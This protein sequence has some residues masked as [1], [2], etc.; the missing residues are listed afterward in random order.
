[1]PAAL[2][3]VDRVDSVR[4]TLDNGCVQ[5]YFCLIELFESFFFQFPYFTFV[6]GSRL[7]V[8]GRHSNYEAGADG[9]SM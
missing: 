4:E 8:E 3:G 9:C 1:M 5:G 6:N 7:G 2:L